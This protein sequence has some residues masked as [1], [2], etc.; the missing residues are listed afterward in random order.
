M[1]ELGRSLQEVTGGDL[2]AGC[3][4]R[5]MAARDPYQEAGPRECDHDIL[6]P[7]IAAGLALGLAIFCKTTAA[8]FG[9]FP[10]LAGILLARQPVGPLLKRLSAIY[11]LALVFP[12]ISWLGMPQVDTFETTNLLFHQTFFFVD[13]LEL[14]KNPLVM[15]P[16]NFSLLTEYVPYYLTW[17]AAV[18]SVVSILY[19]GWRREHGVWLVASASLLPITVQI[20]V[21]QQMFPTRYPFPHIWPLLLLMGIA[22]ARL[23]TDLKSRL[24]SGWVAPV[25]SVAVVVQPRQ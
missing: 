18:A 22:A 8:L 10:A 5:D 17:S 3:A 21:L 7:R 11:G 1:G 19:L 25:V 13:P 23:Q 20:F 14:L 9:F 12:L 6:Y 4:G 2:V 24:G 16:K 15:A